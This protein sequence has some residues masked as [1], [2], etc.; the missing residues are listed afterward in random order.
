M[1]ARIL[2]GARVAREIREELRPQAAELAAA[3]R[4][5]GLGVLLVG[6]DPASAVYVKS[7]TKAADEM[8]GTYESM[9]NNLQGEIT[10]GK[11]Q[12][13]RIRDGIS[14]NMA[15]DILF[16]SG[17][18]DLD[19]T[20]KE[21]LTQVAD[22]LKT[23]PYQVVVTG[24]TDNQKISASLAK[25]YPTNWELGGA[26]AAQIVRVFEQSGIA[27]E[28][29]SA[30]SFADSRPRE[31]N[32]SPEGRTKNRRIE[33]KLVPVYDQQTAGPAEGTKN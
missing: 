6:D 23:N 22:E 5:P 20:G 19:K 29:L 16:K 2:D 17:S 26:R 32:D 24:H 10:S 3:G 12:V 1:T 25:K 13:E 33:I 18:A 21:L 30:V 15:Q 11:L 8:K 31:G 4:R 7:K 28:R 27:K 14:V 9:I